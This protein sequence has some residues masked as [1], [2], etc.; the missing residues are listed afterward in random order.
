MNRF[1]QA[2]FLI[3][4]LLSA[5]FTYCKS[6]VEKNS[7]DK[8]FSE[9]DEI[10]SGGIMTGSFPGAQVLIGNERDILYNKSYGN[11]TYDENS[12][13]VTDY[14]MYDLASVTKVLATTSAIM[15]L[16]DQRKFNLS[17]KVSYYIPEF[18]SNGKEDITILNLLIHNS[19]L[20]AFVPFY[21]YYSNSEEVMDAIYNAELEYPTGS[22]SV[23]SDLNAVILGKLVEKISG[24]DLN[25]Y[26][27]DNIFL[28]LDMQ[29]TMFV[30][31]DSRKDKIAPTEEDTY[32]RGRLLQGE[33]HDETTSMLNG[34]SG[35]AGLFSNARDIY[36]LMSV[37]LNDGRYYNPYTRSLKEERMFDKFTVEL[38]TKKYT[39]VLYENSRALGWDTKPLDSST[40]YRIP[41]GELISE[42]CFG[43]T[44]YTGT[45]VWCDRE[46]KIIVILLT[47][48]VYP[49]RSNYGIRDIR[50]EI[51]NAAIEIIESQN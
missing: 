10:I 40:K 22:Q 15:K 5:T 19:G 31:D 25:Q 39:D 36:K 34:V 18:G 14:T 42:N 37:L 43:H 26:C 17:D 45:S 4:F 1:S 13:V 46:R 28:P 29:N 44:G 12:P 20:T 51:H 2:V 6:E 24:K 32:W 21:K 41:C 38:F 9:I 35:N 47:N 7:A 50:P 33:V 49:S 3:V 16:Y 48:R 8:D 27:I 23:Y 30:P 11:F